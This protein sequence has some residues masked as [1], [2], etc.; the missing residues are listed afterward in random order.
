MYS[1][2]KITF[3]AAQ[4][5]TSR[6]ILGGTWQPTNLIELLELSL[7]KRRLI[8]PSFGTA[9]YTATASQSIVLSVNSAKIYSLGGY[10]ANT[11]ALELKRLVAENG[12]AVSYV[13]CPYNIYIFWYLFLRR[14]TESGATH[15][16]T[17]QSLAGAKIQRFLTQNLR[18]KQHIVRPEWIFDSITLGWSQ[19]VLSFWDIDYSALYF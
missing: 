9:G 13:Y 3:G 17:S 18:N 19:I 11:T 10:C 15:I 1:P 4:L 12:G 7:S 5:V 2:R 6:V 16:L 8:R 14:H